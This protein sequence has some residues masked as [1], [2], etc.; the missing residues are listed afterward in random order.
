MYFWKRVVIPTK[1]VKLAYILIILIF[2]LIIYFHWNYND[3]STRMEHYSPEM[4]QLSVTSGTLNALNMSKDLKYI[5]RWI[6]PKNGPVENGEGSRLF[7]TKKCPWKNCYLTDQSEILNVFSNFRMV[8]FDGPDIEYFQ[9]SRKL[10]KRRS[11]NQKF[12]FVSG[13]SAASLPVCDEL[14]SN[15][16]NWTWTYKLDSD[17]VWRYFLIKDNKGSII[18]PKQDINWIKIDNMTPVDSKFI[19]KLKSKQK[20]AAW[21]VSNCKTQSRREEFVK[22]LQTYLNEYQ[23]EI[24]IYGACGKWSCPKGIMSKCLQILE[25]DYYFYLAFENSISEDFVTDIVLHA[26]NHNT[27]PIVFGGANYSCFLPEGAYLNAAEYG[28]EGLARRMF[29]I[30]RNPSVYQRFFRWKN[31]YSYH[32]PNES[33]ETDNY[34]ALCAAANLKDFKSVS[35]KNNFNTW[36]TKDVKCP[37]EDLFPQ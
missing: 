8:L 23:L 15:Y 3:D 24:D 11:L 5:L 20:I 34:C 29:E 28:P 9:N 36:W 30:M 35:I 26:L 17:L 7:L 2:A 21:F 12:V 10:P 18:G 1:L 33:P 32:E 22:E 37:E 4:K 31:H 27:V 13:D 6:N 16:F 25:R 19:M 14:W